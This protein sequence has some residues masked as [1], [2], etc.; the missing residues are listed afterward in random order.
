MVATRPSDGEPEAIAIALD[1]FYRPRFSGDAL[2]TSP[3]GLAVALADRLDT[4]V[5]IFGIGQRPTGDKTPSPCGGRGS[6]SCVSWSS[7]RCR[8]T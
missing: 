5:G 3:T 1:E 2:P 8:W 6:A 7:E 4:L